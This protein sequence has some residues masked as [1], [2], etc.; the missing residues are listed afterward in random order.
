M[1]PSYLGSGVVSRHISVLSRFRFSI[2]SYFRP[3]LVPE[4]YHI[5]FPSSLGSGVVSHHISIM[6]GFRFSIMS[7]F[8]PV[9]VLKQHHIIFPSSLSSGVVSHQISVLSRF[10][11]SSY[12]IVVL[13]RSRSS[14]TL[15]FRPLQVPE[16]YHV[17]YPSCLGFRFSITSYFRP[18]FRFRFSIILYFCLVQ[19]PDQYHTQMDTAPGSEL[20][21]GLSLLQPSNRFVCINCFGFK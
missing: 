2:M 20:T 19:V 21:Q 8:C 16:Q 5:I 18:L 14:I 1:F 15:H 6:S 11:S 7:Y 13:S 12:H 10:R 9:W 17:I 3:I 4:Q